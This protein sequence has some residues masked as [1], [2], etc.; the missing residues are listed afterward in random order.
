MIVSKNPL[1]EKDEEERYQFLLNDQKDV[2]SLF[3]GFGYGFA[4]IYLNS[5]LQECYFQW[6]DDRVVF[7][8]Q[9]YEQQRQDFVRK[10]ARALYKLKSI[11]KEKQTEPIPS[12]IR[13]SLTQIF[14]S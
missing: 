8:T 6:S 1:P 14:L 10:T 5:R 2:V 9:S 4:A 13:D 7:A 11:P 12:T 3:T